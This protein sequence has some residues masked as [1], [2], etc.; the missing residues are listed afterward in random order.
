MQDSLRVGTGVA[1]RLHGVCN[2]RQA[3]CP[4]SAGWVA[5]G[6]FVGSYEVTWLS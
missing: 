6:V 4:G 1:W 3:G 2:T 5:E